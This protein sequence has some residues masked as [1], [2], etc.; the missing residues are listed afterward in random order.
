MNG[1]PEIGPTSGSLRS[2]SSTGSTPTA[3]ASSSMAD[4][5][6]NEPGAQPGARIHVGVGR[7]TFTSDVRMRMASAAYSALVTSPGNS[8]NSWMVEVWVAV[9]WSIA[10]SL[11]VE[12]APSRTRWSV[13][14]LMPVVAN[15][16]RRVR[17][18]RT[19][20]LSSVV[21]MTARISCGPM[22]LEPKPPPTCSARTRTTPGSRRNST[23]ST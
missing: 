9:S 10:R 8:T 18:T 4:S 5:R 22:P 2:R 11:P 20:R 13:A 12:S 21:A 6:A 16:W 17:A 15:T 23:D 14:A 3:S 19:G 7:L 1:S